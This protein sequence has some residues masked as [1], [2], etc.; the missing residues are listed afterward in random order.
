[1]TSAT[2][3]IAEFINGYEWTPGISLNDQWHDF[4]HDLL[5]EFSPQY[6]QSDIIECF[7]AFRDDKSE[8]AKLTNS[9]IQYFICDH[10]DNE[11]II[12]LIKDM[13]MV[14]DD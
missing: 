12:N 9:Q 1:M 13:G 10:S 14:L 3:R 4:V 6:Y 2:T 7:E 8:K 11:V 5:V